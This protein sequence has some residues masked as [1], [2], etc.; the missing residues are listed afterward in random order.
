MRAFAAVITL[1]CGYWLKL[2]YSRAGADELS[3]VLAPS[4]FIAQLAGVQLVP[5]PG[6]GYI[7]RSAHMVVGPA[8]AGVNFLLASWLALY[9][10]VQ[11]RFK[12][13]QLLCA[14]AL[15]FVAAYLVTISING[16]R[17]ALAAQL[18]SLDIYNAVWT[19]ARVHRLLGVV[20]YSGALLGV[21]ALAQPL[22]AARGLFTGL[23]VYLAVSLGIPLLN[24]A[25]LRD[26]AHFAEHAALTLGGALG[27]TLLFLLAHR[28]C[29]G[30]H[31]SKPAA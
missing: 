31:A 17:I 25:F 7:S 12:P 13:R 30:S 26:P 6:A 21:C 23:C 27:V 20:L 2:S 9:A 18:F 15:C 5:E 14:S 11:A 29:S 10:S 22:R 28:L 19:K 1:L 4:A 3:W 16:L 8:C 24:R